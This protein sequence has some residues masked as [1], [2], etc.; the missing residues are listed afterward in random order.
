MAHAL[1]TLTPTWGWAQ[2]WH[3]RAGCPLCFWAA[4]TSLGV[5]GIPQLCLGAV[6]A[7][8]QVPEAL[9]TW[10]AAQSHSAYISSP[11]M[12]G[13]PCSLTPLAPA[14]ERVNKPGP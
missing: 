3:M 14:A 10:D 5:S 1:G 6:G 13:C 4:H 11:F 12:A 7:M 9:G 8:Q 2:A